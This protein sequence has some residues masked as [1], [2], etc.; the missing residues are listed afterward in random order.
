LDFNLRRTGLGL[1]EVLL[2]RVEVEVSWSITCVYGFHFQIVLSNFVVVCDDQRRTHLAIDLHLHTY[3]TIASDDL[4]IGTT[5]L[6]VA[7]KDL[8]CCRH[9]A[10]TMKIYLLWRWVLKPLQE[11]SDYSGTFLEY[12]LWEISCIGLN[13]GS[14]FLRYRKD[15]EWFLFNPLDYGRIL[16]GCRKDFEGFHFYAMGYCH[17]I[18]VVLS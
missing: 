7:T 16:L 6:G 14:N 13:Y 2:A 8:G 12:K 18:M 9:Y 3:C 17:W 5:D 1:L 10:S 11:T 15:Y 4:G